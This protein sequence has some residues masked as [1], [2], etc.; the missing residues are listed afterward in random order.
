VRG[1]IHA[2]AAI[3]FACAALVCARAEASGFEGDLAVELGAGYANASLTSAAS[4]SAP[5]GGALRG[6]ISYGI[7]DSLG[8]EATAQLAWY[9]SRRPLL[10]TEYTD[11]AG[12][13]VSGYAYGDEFARTR[14]QELGLGLVYALDVLRVV[15]Y[16]GAGVSSLRAVEDVGGETDVDY[17]AALTFEVGADVAL[18]EHVLV[19]AAAVFDVYLAQHTEFTGQ[20]AILV[21]AAFAFS[22]GKVGGR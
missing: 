13:L 9:E 2:A 14:L 16:L 8:V 4:P 19:G 22:P 10:E 18:N 11:D 17:D 5:S 3:A 7:T 1:R 15:P 6:R 20:T 21:R 12:A